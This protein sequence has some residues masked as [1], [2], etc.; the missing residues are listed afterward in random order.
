MSSDAFFPFRD[1]IDRAAQ[2]CLIACRVVVLDFDAIFLIS[3]F[4]DL[5]VYWFR[6]VESI[7]LVVLQVLQL[8][9]FVCKP[10]MNMVLRWFTQTYVFS[11]ISSVKYS[12]I[13]YHQCWHCKEWA[14]RLPL[15]KL[16]VY[17]INLNF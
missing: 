11:I 4:A 6:R 3:N 10:V 7:I 5:L 8:M 13:Y 17:L 1:N 16:I 9:T 15:S 12:K 2:V 14:H